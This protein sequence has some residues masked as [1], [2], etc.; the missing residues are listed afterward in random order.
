MF[1]QPT[2]MK[3]TIAILTAALAAFHPCTAEEAPLPKPVVDVVFVI[4][5][6]GS[7]GRLIAGAKEKIWSI[8]NS[9]VSRKPSPAVRIGLVSYRDR[10]DEYITKKFD[11]T[12]DIDTVFKNLQSLKADGGGDSPESVNQALDEA[13]NEM[14]WSSG[15]DSTKIVFLVGDCPPHMDYKNDVKYQDTCKKAAGSNIIINTVQCGSQSETTQRTGPQTQRFHRTGKNASSQGRQGR[16]LRP[17]SRGNHQG[18]NQ[19][20]QHNKAM[21]C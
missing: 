19:A 17:Q 7:M 14:K 5:S 8:A 6:T 1:H 3:T 20:Q 12:D 13:V 9:I 2:L 18:T 15:K 10:G 21:N 16:F 4:D 11:L